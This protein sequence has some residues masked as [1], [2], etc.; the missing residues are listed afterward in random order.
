MLILRRG[1][2]A[3]P[4][5][6]HL[7]Q[8]GA[9]VRAVAAC[10]GLSAAVT[11]SPSPGGESVTRLYVW[12]TKQLESIIG[13][14]PSA[15]QGQMELQLPSVERNAN[16]VK[17]IALSEAGV[18]VLFTNGSVSVIGFSA[19][20][21]PPADLQGVVVGSVSSCLEGRLFFAITEGTG[22][23]VAWQAKDYGMPELWVPPE[24][25]SGLMTVSC[26]NGQVLAV[27]SN[28]TIISWVLRADLELSHS[29][30]VMDLGGSG[31][32]RGLRAVLGAGFL[33]AVAQDPPLGGPEPAPHRKWSVGTEQQVS[34]NLQAP[35]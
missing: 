3:E 10:S 9:G 27:L 4:P 21:Q 34:P 19:R 35:L 25:Q 14:S 17:S 15:V 1:M 5:P 8:P 12:G 22:Q 29:L 2:L 31:G 18:L 23:L 30:I 26:L 6:R 20:L 32:A 24:A 7:M 33:V 13:F 28:G 16:G 11:T